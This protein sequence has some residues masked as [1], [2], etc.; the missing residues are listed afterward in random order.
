MDAVAYMFV[1]CVPSGL[2]TREFARLDQVVLVCTRLDQLARRTQ[3]WLLAHHH[4][5]AQIHTL[6]QVQVQIHT[7]A[8]VQIQIHMHWMHTHTCIRGRRKTQRAPRRGIPP[9]L[10]DH[11]NLRTDV[12]C[13]CVC[14]CMCACVR[15]QL[16]LCTKVCKKY[17][18]TT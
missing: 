16:C 3:R 7:L 18:C 12:S 1:S 11:Y 5:W 8:Q 6:A 2:F 14:V 17:G 10:L 15:V 9:S 4:A 13:A